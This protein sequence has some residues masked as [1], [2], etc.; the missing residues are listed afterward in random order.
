[1]S[2]PFTISGQI[3][4]LTKV[5]NGLPREIAE[6]AEARRTQLIASAENE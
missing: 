3:G 1:M 5:R 2:L 4:Q 6:P